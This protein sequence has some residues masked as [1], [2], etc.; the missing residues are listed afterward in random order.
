MLKQRL[1]KGGK[2]GADVK[3]ALGKKAK[4]GASRKGK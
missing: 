4:K 3:A 2:K 1:A